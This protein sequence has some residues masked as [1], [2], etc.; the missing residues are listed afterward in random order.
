MPQAVVLIATQI[1]AWATNAALAAG[2]TSAT[3]E[4]VSTISYAVAA[5]AVTSGAL[6][7]LGAALAPK[8]PDPQ[9]L[10][11]PLKQSMP[12]RQS[13]HGRVLAAGAYAFFGLGVGSAKA[14]S[15]DILALLD[16][17]SN[18][19]VGFMLND[20]LMAKTVSGNFWWAPGASGKYGGGGSNEPDLIQIDFRLGLDT[21]SSYSEIAPALPGWDS[22]HRGDGVTSMLLLCTP[23][24]R[25][26]Q[27]GDFPNGLPTPKAIIESQL[28]YDSRDGAQTQGDRSTY[29]Y[30]DNAPLCTLH[31]MTDA[32]GGMGLDYDR[33]FAPTESIN[34]AAFDEAD[35]LVATSGMHATLLGD[36]AIGDT[37]IFLADVTG[38]SVGM[39]VQLP[40]E[41]VVVSGFGLAGEVDISGTLQFSHQAGELAA[42]PGFGQSPLYRIAS[43]YRHDAAAGDVVKQYLSTWDGWI[44][45]RG[46]G[47]IVFRT[48]TVYE[49]TVVLTDRHIIGY[50]LQDYLPDEQ[51][52]N[53]YIV[54]YTDPASL[55]N[56]AEAGY[57]EDDD[58]IAVAGAHPQ[59][60]YLQWVPSAP[61]ALAVARAMLDRNTQPLRGSVITRNLSG[62][63]ALGERYVRLQI[64]EQPQLND[65][66]VEITGK[67]TVNLSN[68]TV[69]FPWVAASSS[70]A[71]PAPTP[72]RV[73]ETAG[74]NGLSATF[75]S[76]PTLGDGL[77]AVGF[78][79]TALPVNTAD[80]WELVE[81]HRGAVDYAGFDWLGAGGTQVI[82]GTMAWKR[83]GASE[84]STQTPF[85]G[86]APSPDQ[87]ALTIIEIEHIGD[88][89]GSLES[90]TWASPPSPAGGEHAL[91]TATATTASDDALGVAMGGWYYAYPEIDTF[92]LK[93][94]DGWTN[95]QSAAGNFSASNVGSQVAATAGTTLSAT[96]EIDQDWYRVLT[97]LMVFSRFTRDTLPPLGPPSGSALQPLDAPT[98]ISVTPDYLDSGGGVSGARLIIEVDDP[99]VDNATWKVQWKLSADTLWTQLPGPLDAEDVP[100]L[101][102]QTG[103]IAASGSIDV[104][105]AYVTASQVSPWSATTTASVAAA[106]PSGIISSTSVSASFTTTAAHSVYYADTSSG[107]ITVTLN[108]APAADEMVE[109]WDSTGH[110]GDQ[111]DQL[112]GNGKNIAG[113][114]TVSNGV[115][116]DFG[117]ARL[118]YDGTQWLMQ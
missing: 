32:S 93:T 92:R 6:Y 53:Q 74:R 95:V 33:F 86:T 111:P 20:D 42:W 96:S 4:A 44:A 34:E 25:E 75:G 114:A 99:G 13:A 105:V 85:S 83:A 94:G 89:P 71:P 79:P 27:Q 50:Q 87:T 64:E 38:L 103:L 7:G 39:T 26:D 66:I 28:V 23:A 18:A 48:N 11:I 12:V 69:S 54:S 1:S 106:V 46:D 102:I 40:T 110:A 113:V 91:A 30:S 84:S 49:P 101:T 59:E 43:I 81:T 109:V 80:G 21:E 88:L 14:L 52:I 58:D 22:N 57:V 56:K 17:R 77:V 72:L 112:R 98:I 10:Q 108:A 9:A 70:T 104:Q 55:Y 90:L 60:L 68:M 97:C 35:G 51:V 16:G 47:A 37:K 63:P 67:P 29:V 115:Q 36:A 73:Q 82:Y 78:A 117:H 2:A 24:R 61:Q 3:A 15:I 118:I 65:I 76:A 45:Q 100:P 31:Y 107:A 116:I 5:T 19:I 41:D 8:V 62:L